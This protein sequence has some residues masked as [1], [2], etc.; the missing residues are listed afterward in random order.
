M[1]LAFAAS[2]VLLCACHAHLELPPAGASREERT[3]SYEQLRPAGEERWR[4]MDAPRIKWTR[5][6]VLNNGNEIT[7]PADLLPVVPPDSAT[8][9]AITQYEE[10]NKPWK[11][12]AP[13]AGY[14][15]AAGA[16]LTLFGVITRIT[17]VITGDAN[18]Y[19]TLGG[20]TLMT[21]LPLGALI[22][23]FFLVPDTE[24]ERH[25]AFNTYDGDLKTAL[26]LD[27]PEPEVPPVTPVTPDAPETPVTP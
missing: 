13:I 5:S 21:V 3:A 22:T 23:G 12:L 26:G 15:F 25:R 4:E 14:G 8:A 20:I 19:T 10:R 6:L 27:R 7:D 2:V 9:I 11:V 16:A 17:G 1:R 24:E 18:L